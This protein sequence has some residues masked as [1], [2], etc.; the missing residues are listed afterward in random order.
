MYSGAGRHDKLYVNDLLFYFL[1]ARKPPTQWYDLNP[2]IQTTY[3]IQEQMIGELDRNHVEY[4]I[5]NLTWDRICEPNASCQS[6]GVVALD[7]YIDANYTPVAKFPQVVIL[8]RSTQ[9]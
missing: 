6:S 1:A 9:F 5:R 3:P 4:V 2:G 7:R 8:R